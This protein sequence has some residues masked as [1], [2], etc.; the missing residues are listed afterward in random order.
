[1]S[2]CS[3]FVICVLF[4]WEGESGAFFKFFIREKPAFNFLLFINKDELYFFFYGTLIYAQKKAVI[5]M[6]LSQ[7]PFAAKLHLE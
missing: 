1:M 5:I 7:R 6:M 2:H 4:L 3:K